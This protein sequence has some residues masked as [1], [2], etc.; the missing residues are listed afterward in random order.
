VTDVDL[1]AEYEGADA[2]VE[3]IESLQRA[4]IDR[5]EAFTPHIVEEVQVLLDRRRG[6]IPRWCFAGGAAGGAAGYAIQ[7]WTNAV[8]YPLNVGGR[9]L[10]SA[11][12]WIPATFE[13]AVLGASLGAVISLL[14]WCGLPRLWHPLFEI[15]GFERASVDRFFL[16]VQAPGGERSRVLD[17]LRGTRALRVQD[18]P[19][20]EGATT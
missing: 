20:E 6:G 19:N 4:G 9:P 17:A 1:V 10:L 2:L 18:L 8:N 11:P 12:A 13:G 7:W 16:H 15:D 14:A 5:L 3:A